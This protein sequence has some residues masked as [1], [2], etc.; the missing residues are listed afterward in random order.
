M[1]VIVV[2][3]RGHKFPD[4]IVDKCWSRNQHGGGFAFIPNNKKQP[5]ITEKGIMT[6]PEFKEKT[7][8]YRGEDGILVVHLRIQ[9]RGGV[10]ATLTHPFDFS[11]PEKLRLLFHN[12]TAKLLSSA[13][14]QSDSSTLATLIK[15]LQD[16][17]CR[18][19]LAKL[20]SGGGNKFVALLGREL[21]I[22]GDNES[23]EKDGLWFSN[24]KHETHDPK[25]T[26][27]VGDG[28]DEDVWQCGY[29]PPH[30]RRQLPAPRVVNE[31]LSADAKLDIITVAATKL[32]ECNGIPL[33]QMDAYA[34]NIIQEFQLRLLSSHEV[35]KLR[36]LFTQSA[37]P[38]LA[39]FKQI[40]L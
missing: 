29:Q 2:K 36:D 35:T 28:G 4:E 6:L 30:P 12:G 26:I 18:A 14:N 20:V 40:L 39:Y 25:Q 11:S 1:C 10:S 37:N 21:F 7:K 19:I 34:Q 23:Q 32:A 38:L 9:S 15:P 22:G 13:S 5:V 31:G 16:D 17:D 3:K 24:I 27:Y 33:D 8:E